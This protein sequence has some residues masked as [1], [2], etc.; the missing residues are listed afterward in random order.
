MSYITFFSP[1]HFFYVNVQ[2]L[3]CSYHKVTN[4]YF[5]LQI[6][7]YLAPKMLQ[8]TPESP[9]DCK[10]IQPVNPKGNQAWI[11]IHWKDWCQSWRSNIW[12]PDAKS[13]LIGKDPDAGKDRRQDE[14]G[15][16][17]DVIVGWHQQLNGHESEQILGDSEGQGS[18]VCCSPWG[19]K[20]SDVT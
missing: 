2:F 15:A 11:F 5:L 20:D 14:T 16:T 4:D 12:P 6:T 3:K 19:C 8:E 17:E 7:D 1:K 10:E 9:L 18:L 13:Q